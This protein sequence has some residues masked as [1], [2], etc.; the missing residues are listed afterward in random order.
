MERRWSHVV[1]RILSH[2]ATLLSLVMALLVVCTGLVAAVR[3]S[4]PAFPVELL[5]AE[6]VS[7]ALEIAAVKAEESRAPAPTPRK[8]RV[9]SGTI[10]RGVTLALSL[11]RNGVPAEFSVETRLSQGAQIQNEFSW[12]VFRLENLASSFANWGASAPV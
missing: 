3:R 11:R 6:E 7:A 1:V 9:T 5:I 12:I 8:D 10:Q 4:A 2:D